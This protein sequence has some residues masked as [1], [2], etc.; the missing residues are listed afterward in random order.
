MEFPKDDERL[1]L[2]LEALSDALFTDEE[3]LTFR[4]ACCQL[5]PDV[6]HELASLFEGVLDDIWSEVELPT[7]TLWVRIAKTPC[8]RWY[9]CNIYCSEL[10]AVT[11]TALLGWSNEITSSVH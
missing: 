1:I 7:P 5:K 8:H 3:W 6:W 9:L 2:A 11:A 10:N 4:Q